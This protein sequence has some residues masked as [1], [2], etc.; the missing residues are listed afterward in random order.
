MSIF[1]EEKKET[2]KKK[3]KKEVKEG[4]TLSLEGI[5]GIALNKIRSVPFK[6]TFPKINLKPRNLSTFV[7]IVLATILGFAG[8]GYGAIYYQTSKVIQNAQ[9]LTN[10]EK[11]DEALNKLSLA[12][13]SWTV[14]KLSVNKQKIADE[15]DK[16]KQLSEDETKY[17]QGVD[18][19]NAG[20]SQETIDLLSEL[21]EESFYYQKAQ[22]K[23]EEAKRKIVEGELSAETTAKLAAE[24]KAKQEELEKNIKA[25]QLSQ[26]EA[27]EQRMNADSDGD[28][29]TYAQ[30]LT[31]GT[32]DL[33]PDS[34]GD[35]VID[36]LDEHPAGGD[37][38]L[39]QDFQWT[40]Q[41]QKWEYTLSIP[42]D[43]Y[44]YYK[45]KPRIPHGTDYV[46]FNDPYVK[47]IAQK[48]K[49]TVEANGYHTTSFLL[50]FVQSL[51][52]VADSYTKFDEL[53]KYPVETIIDRNGD[54]EDTAYL[55]ASLVKAMGLGVALI[56]FND[57]MG[58]GVN[59]VHSQ[60]GYYY[61]VGN[62]WYYYYET[63]GEG[64]KIGD[65]PDEYKYQS[66]KVMVVGQTGSQF[67]Y[68]QYIKPCYAATDFSGYYTDGE[69]YYS[70]SQCYNQIHCL[71]YKGY[72]ANPQV[73]ALYWDSNCSQIV[74]VGCYKSKS[75]PGYFYKSG[76]AWY[77]D[78]RCTQL[79][80]SMS[81]VYPSSLGYTCTQEYQYTSKQNSCSSI[82]AL[83]ASAG[84]LGSPSCGYTACVNGLNQCRSDI[85]EYQ[86]KLNEYNQC[87][88][89]KE[90]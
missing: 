26:K 63:T 87:Y 13:V 65:L 60:S 19:L 44:Q 49:E 72:Y 2:N 33:N 36:S 43:W 57:H 89:R 21:P 32:S 52:Y 55:L 54:C 66:A 73:I 35:G 10:E 18:E 20:D 68:P 14:Q 6:I 64:W 61:P 67:V 85:N 24:A 30:E 28:G 74:T 79:Y 4:I 69:N 45:N 59:T 70:D 50:A 12:Q 88:A 80:K 17:N 86:A 56:Q 46:T 23:I 62:D 16:N 42:D 11:Y 15:I 84:M 22:T 83:C 31:A 47:K 40:Y 77:Y 9:Q 78:S 29:L 41:D 51:P 53:P 76:L 34:D 90:Y 82:R 48:I 1:D 38:N 39:A 71:S 25:Q 58:V 81:C 5:F 3:I 27:E 8:I 7:L 37:R 75:Y